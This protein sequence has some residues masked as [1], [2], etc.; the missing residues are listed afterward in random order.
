MTRGLTLF[1]SQSQSQSQSQSGDR[2]N[3]IDPQSE[4]DILTWIQPHAE[5]TSELQVQRFFMTIC[6]N[7]VYQSLVTE[8]IL[9][10]DIINEN[11]AK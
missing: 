7:V 11:D 5:I 2:E 10:F 3:I 1:E 8:L 4:Q 9:S 6:N